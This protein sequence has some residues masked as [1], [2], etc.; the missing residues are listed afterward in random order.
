V[1]AWFGWHRR[2]DRRAARFETDRTR[3]TVVQL[4][5]DALIEPVR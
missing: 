5:C 3:N 1:I 4:I 2:E